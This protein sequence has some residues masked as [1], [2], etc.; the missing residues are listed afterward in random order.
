GGVVGGG[1][2]RPDDGR[3]VRG[4]SP[5]AA[6]PRLST[7]AVVRSH[8]WR[9]RAGPGPPAGTEAGSV[10]ARPTSRTRTG[11]V[12]A[13]STGSYSARVTCQPAGPFVNVNRTAMPSWLVTGGSGGRAARV[14]SP[15]GTPLPPSPR[16]RV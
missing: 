7:V 11:P 15:V 2:T 10:S 12:R 14:P 13:T 6:A 4:R 3:G 8:A 16:D 5:W 9:S 1:A